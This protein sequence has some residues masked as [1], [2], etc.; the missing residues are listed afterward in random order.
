ML[1]HCFLMLNQ[2]HHQTDQ[3]HVNKL[4]KDDSEIIIKCITFGK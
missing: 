2:A 1:C 3:D 4:V